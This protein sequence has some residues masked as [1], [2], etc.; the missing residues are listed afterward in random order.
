MPRLLLVAGAAV[1]LMAMTGCVDPAPPVTSSP[2]PSATPVFAS[3]EEALAAAEAAYREY[4][5]VSDAITAVGGADPDRLREFVT[6]DELTRAGERFAKLQASGKVTEG[7]TLFDSTSLQRY[8][9]REVIVYL[10]LD[11]SGVRVFD[12]Q[13]QDATPPD[14]PNRLPLE[15][16]FEVGH[17]SQL[18][19]DSSNV[20]DGE[21]ICIL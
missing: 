8:D 9:D 16:T 12:T 6:T 18:L 11:V 17:A 1:I 4:L 21:N 14:R 15:V 7:S 20:W 13:G 10:C 3:E 2:T 5:A 19:L